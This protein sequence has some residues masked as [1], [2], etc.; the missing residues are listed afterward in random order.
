M[1]KTL[2][3]V[4]ITFIFINITNAQ[5]W[6]NKKI[7]GNGNI[8]T[9]IRITGNYK[10]IKCAGSM[11]FILVS[12][13]EGEITLEGDSNILE[14][15]ITE[16]KNNNLIVKLKKNIN[17]NYKSSTIKITIPFEKIDTVSLAGS[18]DLVTENT[19]KT[20]T[21]N[22]SLAGS[23]DIKVDV[24]ANHVTGAIA[25]SGDLTLR[26]KTNKLEAKVAGSGDFHGF[27]LE[28][29][30]TE[31]AVAGSGD[32]QVVSYITLKAQVAGS[33]DVVYKGTPSNKNAKVAGSGS[34]NK[35]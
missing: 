31:V 26:G 4:L 18:G 9:E 34:I 6:D 32:A 21:L 24:Q 11:D 5:S 17:I 3:L 20:N 22:V 25:G 8:T 7:K 2:I 12:G 1:K 23:G 27:N 16:I 19:I 15:V 29:N 13:E 35:L 33:G 28:S 30:H 10:G 14:Y